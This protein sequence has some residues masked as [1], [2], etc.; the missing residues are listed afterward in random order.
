MALAGARERPFRSQAASMAR[1]SAP[2]YA[3]EF[4]DEGVSEGVLLDWGAARWR[5]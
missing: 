4:A 1:T 5:A 2:Q 3:R